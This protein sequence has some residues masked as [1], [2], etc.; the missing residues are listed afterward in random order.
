MPC[1][2]P[3]R[4]ARPLAGC[5]SGRV[6]GT[7]AA[8]LVL[9]LTWCPCLFALPQ[10]DPRLLDEIRSL[11]AERALHPPQPRLLAELSMERLGEQL[12]VID[13]HAR[14]LPPEIRLASAQPQRRIG[15]SVY[16]HQGRIWAAPEPGGPAGRQGIPEIGELKEINGTRV[17]VDVHQAARLIDEAIGNG[18]VNLAIDD[19]RVRRFTVFPEAGKAAPVTTLAAAGSVLLQITDFVS[20]ETAPYFTS[21]YTTLNRPGARLLLDLRGCAGGD[22]FEALE[23]A[24]KFV[25]AGRPLVTTYDRKGKVQTYFSPT[26]GKLPG[27]GG[28][29]VDGRTA[30]AAEVLAG[31]LKFYGIA[32]LIGERSYGKCESQT[33]F[34]LSNGGELWLTTLAIHYADDSTC[35]R[36]GLQPDVAYPD[37]AIARAA[38]IAA[39]LPGARRH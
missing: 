5:S 31:A 2:E 15:L 34:K 22:L 29:L 26:G 11:I 32:P 1:T 4:P 16:V 38:A 20:H 3:G 19:G 6:R 36:V 24:G 33:V 7:L 13:S 8:L 18:R 27:L 23:I 14:Y 37:I 10:A 39:R 21:L 17:G 30:S 28:V 12:L 25:P 9:L 35:D